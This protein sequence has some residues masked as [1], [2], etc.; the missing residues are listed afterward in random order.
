[1]QSDTVIP[2]NRY[3]LITDLAIR[4]KNKK[5]Q[6]GKTILQK[7][8][9]ILQE[10]YK[11][12]LGYDFSLYTYGPYTS[13]VFQDLDVTENLEGVQVRSVETGYGGYKIL[14][15]KE[16]ARIRAKGEKYLESLPMNTA[17]DSLMENFGRYTARELELRATIIFIDRDLR[18]TPQHTVDDLASLLNE[19]KP[20]FSLKEITQVIEE[21]KK[22]GYVLS[23]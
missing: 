20:K 17:L 21:M 8:I 11:I 5:V 14:P 1:M 9:F 12:P 19:I 16:N 23:Q 15:G 4:F 2:W 13:E 10:I 22:S 3:A 18:G 7:V 6:F